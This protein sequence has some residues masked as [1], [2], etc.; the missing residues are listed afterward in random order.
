[1]YCSNLAIEKKKQ[2]R[3]ARD[4]GSGGGAASGRV[5]GAS[6]REQALL[7]QAQSSYAAGAAFANGPDLLGGFLELVPPRVY[8]LHSN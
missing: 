5:G 7:G 1:M 8:V 3:G 4:R 2:S 6:Q